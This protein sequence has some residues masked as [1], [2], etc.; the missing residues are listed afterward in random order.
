[1][2][3]SVQEILQEI[4]RQAKVYAEFDHDARVVRVID[5]GMKPQL[6]H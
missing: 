6:S 5:A 4:A 3:G 1:M 2:E